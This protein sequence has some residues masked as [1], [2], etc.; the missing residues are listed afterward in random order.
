MLVVNIWED[1]L[2]II[3]KIRSE[4]F[5]DDSFNGFFVWFGIVLFGVY[6][7]DLW[8]EEVDV[9]RVKDWSLILESGIN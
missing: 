2:F 8:V 7:C 5:Y 1:F 4:F 3:E 9:R 6:I